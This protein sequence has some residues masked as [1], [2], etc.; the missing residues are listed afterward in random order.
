MDKHANSI[1]QLVTDYGTHG[2]SVA[3]RAI[4]QH[5]VSLSPIEIETLT[6]L[7]DRLEASFVRF[8]LRNPSWGEPHI[9]HSCGQ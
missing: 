1:N 6:T 7:A 4:A 3:L 5:N 2:A 8:R 9:C